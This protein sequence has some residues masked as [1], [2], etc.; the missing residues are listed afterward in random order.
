MR[1]GPI[2]LAQASPADELPDLGQAS[3]LVGADFAE[4]RD[5]ALHVSH[6]GLLVAR[7]VEEIGQVVLERGLAVAVPARATERKRL[8]GQLE[9]GLQPARVA[10]DEREVVQSRRLCRWI[11]ELARQ[12]EA[13]LEL[14]AGGWR[15]AL[16]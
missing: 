7:G 9:R 4:D 15:V 8:F 12:L 1:C 2:P 10:L 6:G 14:L 11:A 16:G 3:C 5:G 13:E